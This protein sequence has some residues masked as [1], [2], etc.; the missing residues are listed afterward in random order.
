MNQMGIQNRWL[1]LATL[2]ILF[3]LN[4]V[5][6]LEQS[7]SLRMDVAMNAGATNIEY[8]EQDSWWRDDSSK[9]Y[10]DCSTSSSNACDSDHSIILGSHEHDDGWVS[11]SREFVFSGRSVCYSHAEIEM[12]IQTNGPTDSD[13]PGWVGAGKVTQGEGKSNK[14]LFYAW[15]YE[16]SNWDIINANSNYKFNNGYTGTVLTQNDGRDFRWVTTT[17]PLEGKIPLT[18]RK[19]AYFSNHADDELQEIWTNFTMSVRVLNH[20]AEDDW[21]DNDLRTEISHMKIQLIPKSWIGT[22]VSLS[23]MNGDEIS[24]DVYFS[25]NIHTFTGQGTMPDSCL[26]AEPVSVV[27]GN[28]GTEQYATLQGPELDFSNMDLADGE[29]ELEFRHNSGISALTFLRDTTPPEGAVQSVTTDEQGLNVSM[30]NMRDVH[31]G[32]SREI[33]FSLVGESHTGDPLEYTTQRSYYYLSSQNSGRSFENLFSDVLSKM[34]CEDITLNIKIN[35]LAFPPNEKILN[36]RVQDTC[37]EP[38][39]PNFFVQQIFDSGSGISI[40]FKPVP[41]VADDVVSCT[42]R[43]SNA[44]AYYPEDMQSTYIELDKDTCELGGNYFLELTKISHLSDH[45][46]FAVGWC[47]PPNNNNDT[48]DSTSNLTEQEDAWFEEEHRRYCWTDPSATTERRFEVDSYAPLISYHLVDDKAEPS[49]EIHA[50]DT[51]GI[52]HL[53]VILQYD[54]GAKTVLEC[55]NNNLNYSV[56]VCSKTLTELQQDQIADNR[57]GPLKNISIQVDDVFGN[58]GETSVSASIISQINDIPTGSDSTSLSLGDALI[59]FVAVGLFMM[60]MNALTSSV[61]EPPQVSLTNDHYTPRNPMS[62]ST[63]AGSTALFSSPMSTRGQTKSLQEYGRT[64]KEQVNKLV[65]SNPKSKP[66]DILALYKHPPN[67]T[68]VRDKTILKHIRRAIEANRPRAKPDIRQIKRLIVQSTDAAP[69]TI[70]K[71]YIHPPHK[72]RVD[73]SVLLTIIADKVESIDKDRK[74]LNRELDGKT[75]IELLVF[76]NSLGF[77]F[78]TRNSKK[79]QLLLELKN[80]I[81]IEEPVSVL[82]IKRKSE[83]QPEGK[84]KDTP[85]GPIPFNFPFQCSAGAKKGVAD[86]EV[87]CLYDHIDSIMK[88]P[89]RWLGKSCPVCEDGVVEQRIT[90]IYFG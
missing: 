38:Q 62:T 11:V 8:G 57:K 14:L 84:R 71:G 16:N 82:D 15:D 58:S 21:N 13:N 2:L 10:T 46:N 12:R 85:M 63:P 89:L 4:T 73:E 43:V 3:Q 49:L 56:Q 9:V 50:S 72:K 17:I 31:S 68:R 64:D 45:L 86:G 79:E 70:L 44:D 1:V 19:G 34:D 20:P 22:G 48:S 59:C 61:A 32:L 66:E 27:V 35:D 7:G 60:V 47:E 76:A 6:A 51:S 36:E 25:E 26:A 53:S 90:N 5:Q 83:V 29:V 69:Q 78:T 30:T 52:A 41:D 37:P 80:F 24:S 77:Q 33:E 74:D 28:N 87:M 88:K 23:V 81:L 67:A 18:D 39:A 55:S 42:M 54:N 40:G 65:K 75:V